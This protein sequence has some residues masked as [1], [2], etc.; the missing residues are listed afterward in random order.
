[1]LDIIVTNER[2]LVAKSAEALSVLK[3][4]LV[5]TTSTCKVDKR[6]TRLKKRTQYKWE[7]REDYFFTEDDSPFYTI[8]RGLV[9]L[10][11]DDEFNKIY[12]ESNNLI[13]PEVDNEEI[14]IAFLVM[15]IF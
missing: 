10:L 9:D 4:Y 13:I 15:G 1:M 11:P 5:Y 2:A 14:K 6:A 12:E 8:P 7:V 3:Y